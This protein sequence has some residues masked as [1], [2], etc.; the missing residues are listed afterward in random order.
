MLASLVD[1]ALEDDRVAGAA[2]RRVFAQLSLPPAGADHVE[3][4]AR[5]LTTKRHGGVDGV[6]DLLVGHE[7]AHHGDHRVRRLADS[8]R[9]DGVGAVVDD[10]DAL[11]VHSELLELVACRA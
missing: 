6:L 8:Y 5:V 1:V 10:G 9:D 11:A 2:G 3:S 7:A 4:Q